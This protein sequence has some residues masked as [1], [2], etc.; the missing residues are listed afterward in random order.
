[1]IPSERRNQILRELA[2][3]GAFSTAMFTRRTGLSAMTIRRDL[4]SL[5]AQGRLERVHGGAIPPAAMPLSA[6]P[7]ASPPRPVSIGMVVPSAAYYY[8]R[9]IA[10]AQAAAAELGVR[11]VLATSEYSAELER[12]QLRRMVSARLDGVIV[13]PAGAYPDDPETYRLMATL[14]IPAVLAERSAPGVQEEFSGAAIS[15]DHH[16][17]AQ[18][19]I[20]HLTDLGHRRIALAWRPSPTAGP[21]R[22]G[23]DHA[24]DALAA[25]GLSFQVRIPPRGSETQL[26]QRALGAFLDRCVATRMTAVVMLP[27]DA[28]VTL[29]ELAHDRGIDVP[30]QLSV[31][32]YDDETASLAP[33]PLTAIAPPKADVG[34]RSV[35]ACHE[36]LTSDQ[37]RAMPRTSLPPALVVRESTG[38]VRAAERAESH[39]CDSPG[40]GR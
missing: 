15:S 9:V 8:P 2:L 16:L 32:A 7:G 12:R 22:A 13:T 17:G 11:L 30:S 33:V 38:P 18:L 39:A 4:D 24:M 29:I 35:R 14:G 28:A 19:A 26:T 37:A 31:V 21:V 27:D 25:D 40:S 1:M 3:T 10:G 36:Q 20:R 23:F 5:A 6:R 34:Y